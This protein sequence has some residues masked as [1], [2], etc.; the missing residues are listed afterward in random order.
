MQ[1]FSLNF[2]KIDYFKKT[3]DPIF[4]LSEFE[5]QTKCNNHTI[6]S[7]TNVYF[8]SFLSFFSPSNM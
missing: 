8:N 7:L 5:P 4:S 6:E 2:W 1:L 3:H